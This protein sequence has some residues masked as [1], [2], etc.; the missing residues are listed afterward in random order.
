LWVHLRSLSRT[1]VFLKDI[2]E[3]ELP[4]AH[5]EGR[6]VVDDPGLIDRWR[7][8][9]QTA[10]VYL[11][12]QAAGAGTGNTSKLPYPINPNGST[13]N[14]AGLCDPSG[15][16]LGLMPHPERFQFATQHPQWT[17]QAQGGGEG[18]GLKIFRNAIEYFRTS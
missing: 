18:A 13:A 16:V 17:R 8:G 5:A 10:L 15:R 3:I 1:C 14:I 12:P 2:D 9:G 11:D 6:L 7:E 4:I